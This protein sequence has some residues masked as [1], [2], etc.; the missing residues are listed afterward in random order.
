MFKINRQTDYAIRMLLS[1]AKRETGV[2]ASTTEIQKEMVIPHSFAQRVV[3]NLARG[4]FIQTYPGRDGGMILARPAR[5][6]NLRQL[7]EHFETHLFVSDCNHTESTCP[8]GMNCPICTQWEK[9]QKI[10]AEEL[11]RVNFEDLANSSRQIQ[12][13]PL[14][15]LPSG[16]TLELT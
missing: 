15:C 7:L 14:I 2:R 1:L 8:L 3:A 11:E 6:I 4:S 10:M 13:I 5:E 16:K 9:L 12:K